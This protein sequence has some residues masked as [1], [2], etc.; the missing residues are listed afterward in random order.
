MR[1]VSADVPVAHDAAGTAHSHSTNTTM[2]A[3]QTRA[4]IA[5]PISV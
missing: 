1:G 2:P 4:L 5:I 3:R